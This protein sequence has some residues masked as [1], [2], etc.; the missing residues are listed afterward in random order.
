MSGALTASYDRLTFDIDAGDDRLFYEA[1]KMPRTGSMASCKS[2]TLVGRHFIEDDGGG[3]IA[4]GH[5]ERMSS[6]R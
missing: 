3:E 5:G 4:V 2:W 1:G 6:Q